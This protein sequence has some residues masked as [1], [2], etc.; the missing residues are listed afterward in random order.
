MTVMAVR[1]C[2]N[3]SL[4]Q[5][6]AFRFCQRFQTGHNI[7]QPECLGPSRNLTFQH[8]IFVGDHFIGITGDDLQHINLAEQVLQ[9]CQRI[10]LGSKIHSPFRTILS[11]SQ[12][13][14]IDIG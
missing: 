4:N 5:G 14:H 2:H 3:F 13:I 9:L 8:L 1:F 6:I 10:D 7:F 12:F 11:Q